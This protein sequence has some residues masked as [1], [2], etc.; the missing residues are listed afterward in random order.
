M[1]V[2]VMKRF[3][4]I[5]CVVEPWKAFEPAMERAVTLAQN[6]Q[7]A[8]TVISVA[9]YVE[10][11]FG[12]PEGGPISM[13]LQAEVTASHAQQLET[14]VQPYRERI[15]LET[16]VL[17]GTPFL[18]IVRE[19]LRNGRD[20]VI[21]I[22]EHQD[23]LDRMLGSDDMHLLRKCP[24]P[25]WL[26]KPQALKAYRR[27]LAAVDVDDAYPPAELE[28]RRELNHLILEMASSLAV[29]DFAELH[30]VHAWE[31]VAENVMRHGIFMTAP[32]E[33][34]NAYVEKVRQHHADNMDALLQAVAGGQG[35]EALDYLKP[36][37]HLV[38]GRARKEI[39]ALA[40]QI[41]ADLV[42][43]GTVARTG[44]SGFI[45]GNTAETILNQLDCSVLA[46]KPPGFETP[47]SVEG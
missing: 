33:K 7:A 20:L 36:E 31:A 6:N 39:P 15:S 18:E 38:K 46:I 17:V 16:K 19:V 9:P 44:V 47:V 10:L 43:M 13:D 1:E 14:L 2:T 5:L 12:M 34:V 41:G 40:S 42:V 24:C 27:I 3:K 11:S 30:I 21:R 28:A 8:L 25:V 37:T 23:W 29:A 22:P 32:E 45:M 4:N 26:I 35:R